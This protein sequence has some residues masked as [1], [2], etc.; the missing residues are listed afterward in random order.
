[1]NRRNPNRRGDEMTPLLNQ[2]CKVQ[3]GDWVRFRKVG[4]QPDMGGKD[5]SVC[6]EVRQ[7]RESGFMIAVGAWCTKALKSD[8]LLEHRPKEI[9]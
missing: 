5:K 6:G 9:L 4:T 7:V 8:T 1:M 2:W 3:V